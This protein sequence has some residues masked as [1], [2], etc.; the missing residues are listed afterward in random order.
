MLVFGEP[1][2]ADQHGRAAGRSRLPS[3]LQPAS[4]S[5][6]S[7]GRTRERLARQRARRHRRAARRRADHR[8]RRGSLALLTVLLLISSTLAFIDVRSPEPALAAV[9]SV[10]ATV[11][12]PVQ[13]ALTWLASPLLQGVGGIGGDEADR[14]RAQ[15]EQL[16]A[17]LEAAG[18]QGEDAGE[19]A[20]LLGLHNETGRQAVAGRVLAYAAGGDRAITIDLGST[21]GVQPGASVLADGGLVGRVQTVALT[22]SVV[23]LISDPGQVVSARLAASKEAGVLTGSGDPTV[24]RLQIL[25]PL[26]EVEEGQKV[27]TFASAAEVPYPAGLPIGTVTGIT[28]GQGRTEVDVAPLADLTA[29]STVLVLTGDPRAQPR[30]KVRS[31]R[32]GDRADEPDDLLQDGNRQGDSFDDGAQPDPTPTETGS[33]P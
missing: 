21:D 30:P 19:L 24:L 18:A 8:R 13:V 33:Q 1:K 9:R 14:M 27:R 6:G 7:T 4:R 23:G 29:L 16:T 26:A 22:T 10:V 31:G 5:R 32:V 28:A 25:D 17:D 2:D 20:E 12:A 11:V 3:P 15:I